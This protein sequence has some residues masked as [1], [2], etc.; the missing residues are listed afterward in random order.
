MSLI[1]LFLEKGTR[2][3]TCDFNKEMD[4]YEMLK[5]VPYSFP[6]DFDWELAALGAYSKAQKERSDKA[7]DAWE[8]EHPEETSPELSA[9]R[10]LEKLNVYTDADHYSPMKASNGFYTRRLAEYNNASR[11][12]GTSP[13]IKIR[14]RNRRWL[15][16]G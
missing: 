3:M 14:R 2:Y 6:A 5:W 12:S 8:K 10:E 9:F 16:N 1:E 4:A 7:L 15:Y 13:K 11:C